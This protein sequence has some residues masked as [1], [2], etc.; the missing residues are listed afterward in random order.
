M[1]V[2]A[3]LT[4]RDKGGWQQCVDINSQFKGQPI[5]ENNSYFNFYMKI[6]LCNLLTVQLEFNFLFRLQEVLRIVVLLYH[7]KKMSIRRKQSMN[8]CMGNLLRNM[9]NIIFLQKYRVRFSYW[10]RFQIKLDNDNE[11]EIILYWAAQPRQKC[12]HKNGVC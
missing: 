8:L 5:L 11:S 9:T 3:V 12:L 1:G 4:K 7:F 10:S 2:A 6:V